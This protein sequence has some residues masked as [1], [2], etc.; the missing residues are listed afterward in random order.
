MTSFKDLLQSKKA[1]I[2]HGAL[3]TE[4]EYKGYDI[5][6]K[7][8]SAKYLLEKPEAIQEIHEEYVKAGSD[9]I[10]T[11]SYQASIKGLVDYGI[12][13]EEARQV[14]KSSVEIAKDAI[15]KVWSE[16]SEDEKASRLYP[17]INGDVGPYA[18]YLA[19]GSEYTGDY[20]S[21]TKEELKDFHRERIAILLEEGSDLLALETI[22][23][24]LEVEALIEL[25]A[26]EFADS[27]AYLSV[28]SQ[29]GKTLSDGTSI[30]DFMKIVGDSKQI[31]ALGLNCSSAKNSDEF[32]KKLASL[33]DKPLVA[34][35]NS[36]EIYDGATQSWKEDAHA[37]SVVDYSADWLDQGV[38]V[39][40]GCCRTRPSHIEEL[41]KKIKQ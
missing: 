39:I 1:L 6:G 31:L 14:I 13:Q 24:I 12:T 38:K 20:G 19:D 34:Y 2:L 33:T 7:L 11:S 10:T 9:L 41:S 27:E 3:G 23:N 21:I 17:L 18:G 29:D 37:C 25:L 5:S 26:E 40:G 15:E 16:L 35:P 22:P 30:E 8:W 32:L 4:L 36:G 28:T